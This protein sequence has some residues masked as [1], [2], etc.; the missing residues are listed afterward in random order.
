MS[1]YKIVLCVLIERQYSLENIQVARAHHQRATTPEQRGS[2]G[3]SLVQTVAARMTRLDFTPHFFMRLIT[4]ISVNIF[5]LLFSTACEA[6]IQARVDVDISTVK[7]AFTPI[8]SWF[9]YDESN[10]TT[11]TGGQALLRELHDLSPVPINIRAHFLLASDDGKPEL[12]WSSSNVYTEDASGSPVY[13]W[14]VLDQIFDAYAAAHVRP[15]VELGSMPKALSSHP[16]PYHV[17]WLSRSGKKPG[18]AFP[19]K[20]YQ[21]WGELVHEVAAHMAQRYGNDAV[22]KWYWEVWNEPDIGGWQ[23]TVE[24]YNKLYDYAVAGVRS[25][26]PNAR[27]GGPAAAGPALAALDVK[28][29]NHT[30][31]QEDFLRQH[32]GNHTQFLEDFLRHC[33]TETSAATGQAV[34][35]DFISIHVKGNPVIEKGHVRMG[36]NVELASAAVGFAVV[37]KFPQLQNLP[38][39]LSE[40]DPDGCAACKDPSLAYRNGTLYPSYTAAA[41]KGLFELQ[42]RYQIN[43]ISMLTWAFEFEG[44]PYFAGFRTL[45]TNGINKPVINVFRMAGLMSG[46]RVLVESSSAVPLNTIL[47]A[48]VTQQP[49]VDALATAADN[50]VAVMLWNY[51]DDDTPGPSAEVDLSV[52]GFPAAAH[53]ALVQQYKIDDTHSNA[54]TVWKRLGSPQSPTHEQYAMLRAAGAL[55]LDGSPQWME[56]ALGTVRV[57]LLLPRQGVSLFRFTW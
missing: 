40:A 35:L 46:N 42:D 14:K 41:L 10:Y 23:G 48:G 13:N 36:L 12:K 18:Y 21:R 26:I 9:G 37:K 38:I 52:K 25:A 39:I 45:S 29:V 32:A 28:G 43:L 22:A 56:P 3:N 4:L 17:S 16:E 57:K 8:Y 49:D 34:P 50:E 7:G 2:Q 1:E 19:P 44:Q 47:T 51:H 20:D 15:M 31:M 11:T 55:Q 27:V 54:Y 6:Q 30:Q 33:M 24:E 53:R 5:F